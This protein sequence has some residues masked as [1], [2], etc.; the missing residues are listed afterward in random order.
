MVLR[1]LLMPI[2]EKQIRNGVLRY[3]DMIDRCKTYDEFTMYNTLREI[4]FEQL[5]IHK[6]Y[7][8]ANIL[9]SY[10]SHRATQI[11]KG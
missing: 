6:L 7:T 9:N 11:I 8:R 5:L 1:E 10:I 2:S 3:M 4:I